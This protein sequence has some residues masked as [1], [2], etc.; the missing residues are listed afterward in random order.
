MNPAKPRPAHAKHASEPPG[1]RDDPSVL[2]RVLGGQT[3]GAPGGA[4]CE[5]TVAAWS[6]SSGSLEDGRVAQSAASCLLRPAP[7]DRVLVWTGNDEG[8]PSEKK[9]WVLSVIERSGDDALVLATSRPLAV[10]APSVGVSTEKMHIAA[11]D[12]LTSTRNRHAVEDTRTETVRV[13][14]A[15]VGTDIRRADTVHD[16]VRG[17]FLQRAGTWISN[18]LRDARLRARTFLFD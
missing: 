10:K 18:T 9:A 7:G 15:Q 11:G 4:L 5:A 14:V 16:D 8:G 3:G 17:T 6:E 1:K 2:E 13:R 12:F